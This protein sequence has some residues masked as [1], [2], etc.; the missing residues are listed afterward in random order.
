MKIRFFQRRVFLRFSTAVL[1]FSLAACTSIGPSSLISGRGEYTEAIAISND[2]QILSYIVAMRYTQSTTLL[3]VSS[4]TANFNVVANTTA[5]FGFGPDKNYV[6][7]IVPLA[8]GIAYEENPTIS[9]TP[10]QGEKYI[11]QLLSPIPLD[12]TVLLSRAA[13][14]IGEMMTM[15]VRSINGIRNPDFLTMH[16]SQPDSDFTR[17]SELFDELWDAGSLELVQSDDD[18]V[19]FS[20]ALFDYAPHQVEQVRE[21]ST[22]LDL[23]EP[24]TP[25]ADWGIPLHSSIEGRGLDGI[26]LQIRSVHDLMLIAAASIDVPE[27]HQTRGVADTFPPLGPVGNY[28]RIHHSKEKPANVSVAVKYRG[29]W[30]YIEETDQTSKRFFQLVEMLTGARIADAGHSKRIAPLLTIPVS[31]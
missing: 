1:V 18:P 5:Q 20:L 21:L 14:S 26:A 22:L 23:P 17:V 6:G 12:L 2:R 8:A 24:K 25:G 28:I 27:E 15:L 31:R 7:N 9:Y 30:F 10:V 3:T 19:Q 16:S 4:I 29:W 11:R 13:R